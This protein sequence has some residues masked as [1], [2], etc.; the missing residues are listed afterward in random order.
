MDIVP[1]PREES[2][3]LDLEDHDG[4]AAT[5]GTG[6]AMPPHPNLRAGLETCRQLQLYGSTVT[7]VD[8]LRTKRRCILEAHCQPICDVG[9]PL[10]ER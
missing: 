3:R 1:Y 6:F 9:S 10:P 8:M 4:V 2:V 7:Q 5:I